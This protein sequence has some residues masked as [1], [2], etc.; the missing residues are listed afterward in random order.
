MMLT[1]HKQKG[2][3]LALALILMIPLILI[4]SALMQW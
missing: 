3:V 1:M 2:M 4:A